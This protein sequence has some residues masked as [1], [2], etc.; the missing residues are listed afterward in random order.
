MTERSIAHGTF[1]VERTYPATPARVFAAWADPKIKALWFGAPNEDNT[2]KIFEFKVGGREYNSGTGP[3]GQSYTFDVQYRD[4]VPDNRIVYTY[5]MELNDKRISVSL[6]TIELKPE[7]SG[8]HM[9]VTEMGAFLDGLDTIKQRE[10]G[11]A[12]LLDQLGAE[13][14]RQVA[15]A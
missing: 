14:Q 8:T 11:T 4:I 2:P 6:A 9:V 7:G 10:E 12:W 13:L 15:S 5:E 3:D 1:T